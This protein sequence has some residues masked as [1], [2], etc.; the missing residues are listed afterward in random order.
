MRVLGLAG[1]VLALAILGYLILGYLNEAG[2]A[3]EALRSLP[4]TG[5]APPAD[6][7]RRG[8]EQRLSPILDRER[9]RVEETD[10]AAGQ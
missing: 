3:Q 5:S 4:P 8:L 9:Q 1:V 6:V 7:S 2:K 10:R